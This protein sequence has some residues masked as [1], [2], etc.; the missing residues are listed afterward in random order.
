M[1]CEKL[2][3]LLVV[4]E[5]PR[6]ASGKNNEIRTVVLSLVEN[7]LAY[8][9][10]STHGTFSDRLRFQIPQDCIEECLFKI[11]QATSEYNKRMDAIQLKTSFEY[12]YLQALLRPFS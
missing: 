3:K 6:L 1:I 9:Q 12:P 10:R 8:I 11:N 4:S 7:F 2:E 5:D